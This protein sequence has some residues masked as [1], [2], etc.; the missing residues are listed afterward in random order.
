MLSHFFVTDSSAF[1]SYEQFIFFSYGQFSFFSY[2]QFSFFQLQIVQFFLVTD[3]SAF[4]SGKSTN[5]FWITMPSP[6]MFTFS[7]LPPVSLVPL[8]SLVPHSP[9]HSQP[10]Q[11][12]HSSHLSLLSHPSHNCL[13]VNGQHT[14][15]LTTHL[16]HYQMSQS[17]LQT[18]SSFLKRI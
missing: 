2:R 13:C 17:V 9:P 11:P 5:L 15:F 3:S 1:F 7:H 4:T 18:S 8:V 16:I 6:P 14:I 10:S 12:S